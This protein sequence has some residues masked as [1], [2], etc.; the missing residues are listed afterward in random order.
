MK[1]REC[2]ICKASLSGMR[3]DASRGHRERFWAAFP[4]ICLFHPLLLL[5]VALVVSMA[6]RDCWDL[7]CVER[8]DIPDD[9]GLKVLVRVLGFFF[10]SLWSALTTLSLI[11]MPLV[12]WGAKHWIKAFRIVW[13]DVK[14][15]Y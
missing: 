8:P 12:W 6:F 14:G 2:G 13:D 9:L 10:G 3:R 5:S 1:N 15:R 7:S 11:M 4:Y